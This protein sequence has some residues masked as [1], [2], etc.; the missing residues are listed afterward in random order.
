[1]DPKSDI[2]DL[3]YGQNLKR[4]HIPDPSIQV[5]LMVKFC[6]IDIEFL[7]RTLETLTRRQKREASTKDDFLVPPTPFIA[8][9]F[10]IL[11]PGEFC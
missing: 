3:M 8:L 6:T 2:S 5:K 1:M 7:S 10:L 9:S 11:S 4:I